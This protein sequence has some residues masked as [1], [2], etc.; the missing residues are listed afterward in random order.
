[1][2][3]LILAALLAAT[4]A[5]S[6]PG[7]FTSPQHLRVDFDFT[8]VRPTGK[9]EKPLSKT[10]YLEVPRRR[11]GQSAMNELLNR[12]FYD[13][14]VKL[15]TREPE[16]KAWLKLV[17]FKSAPV[18]TKAMLAAADPGPEALPWLAARAR[19]V[20][21]PGACFIVAD[22]GR[23]DTMEGDDFTELLMNRLYQAHQ[24]DDAQYA[25]FFD[26]YY[27]KPGV[28]QQLLSQRAP[29]LANIEVIRPTTA[30]RK[31]PG[32]RP[33][34]SGPVDSGLESTKQR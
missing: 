33:I 32:A 14:N 17:R 18:D 1:M 26:R 15:R 4:P 5:P 29:R 11:A 6:G 28:G 34:A 12:I 22:D 2:T 19:V 21:E 23:Y 7:T 10:W 16:D 31:Q 3:P 24:V 20:W 8:L 27:H 13:A 9:Q 25:S 30:F